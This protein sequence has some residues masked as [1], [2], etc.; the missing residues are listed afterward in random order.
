MFPL[1]RRE[2]LEKSVTDCTEQTAA[3]VLSI[4]ATNG[5]KLIPKRVT[6]RTPALGEMEYPRSIA[7]GVEEGQHGHSITCGHEE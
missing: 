3:H 7:W 6:K 4:L 2:A 5:D 1:V